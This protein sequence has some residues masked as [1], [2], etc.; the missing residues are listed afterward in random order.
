ME[1]ALPAVAGVQEGQLAWSLKQNH[2]C[3]RAVVGIHKGDSH[4]CHLERAVQG[5]NMKKPCWHLEALLDQACCDGRAVD[6]ACK[7]RHLR[8]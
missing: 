3:P 1:K 7:K 6:R 5:H 4:A 8:V 2:N